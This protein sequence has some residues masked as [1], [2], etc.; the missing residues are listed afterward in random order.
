MHAQ[1]T[2]DAGTR[3]IMT[4]GVSLWL[5]EEGD[6]KA[7]KL[8]LADGVSF[9]DLAG[10]PTYETLT[11]L[12]PEEIRDASFVLLG[13]PE[14]QASCLYLSAQEEGSEYEDRYWVSLSTRL[15]RRADVLFDGQP[16]Y[17]L[18][19]ELCEVLTAEDA[20]LSEH[21][22]LPDGTEISPVTE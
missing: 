8:R 7:K 14:G 20:E 5:W 6:R 15:L 4:D 21:F 1:L 9:D 12:D 3:H 19:E 18:R 22:R 17:Q 16:V 10:I 2:G 13:K 11:K